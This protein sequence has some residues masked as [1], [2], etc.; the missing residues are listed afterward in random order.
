MKIG[1]CVG[2]EK[3]NAKKAKSCGADY[4]EV[5]F[6]GIADFSSEEASE[7]RKVYD[8]EGVEIYAS[9]CML[10]GD[11]P[12]VVP[13]PKFDL[14]KERLDKSFE[15]ASILGIK[16]VVLGS[17]GARN[18]PENSTKEEATARFVTVTKNFIAPYFKKYDMTCVIE[19]LCDSTLITN[20]EE[21]YDVVEKINHP[22]VKLLADLFHMDKMNDS[23]EEILK[24]ST[25][26]KHVHIANEK[27]GRC[28]PVFGDGN[29]DHYKEFFKVLRQIGY[30]GG[31]SIEANS[32]GEFWETS[33][34]A[35][36]FLKSL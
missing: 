13:E 30:D 31:V 6:R 10:G 21:G 16:N 17:G 27:G 7:I 14:L 36:S 19:P 18:I 28:F 8:S 32:Q 35:I 11:L 15:I 3:D 1:I 20:L 22:N 34:S 5:G 9:N 4:I 24:Y 26:L 2:P 25:C 33:K 29:E 23:V 12:I